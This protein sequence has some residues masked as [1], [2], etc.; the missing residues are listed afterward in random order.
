[1][2][3]VALSTLLTQGEK[4]QVNRCSIEFIDGEVAYEGRPTDSNRGES[5]TQVG[6]LSK[7][8]VTTTD[9]LNQIFG[10]IE[11]PAARPEVCCIEMIDGLEKYERL[12]DAGRLTLMPQANG[13]W[14]ADVRAMRYNGR[15]Y[16]T[17]GSVSEEELEEL[18]G[19]V[20]KD[21][22]ASIGCLGFGTREELVGDDSRKRN[23][24]AVLV[25][26]GDLQ[27]IA[28]LFA[29]TRVMAVMNDLGE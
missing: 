13:T 5:T 1:L 16:Q 9:T 23:Q 21:F 14:L 26:A 10:L 28:G 20:P 22:F 27:A 3:E 29:A 2:D 19:Q 17:L 15:T 4:M 25:K 18:T 6:K 7:F 24:L 8:R 11:W 12:E